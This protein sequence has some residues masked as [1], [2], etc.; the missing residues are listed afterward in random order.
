MEHGDLHCTDLCNEDNMAAFIVRSR[1]LIRNVLKV[2][3]ISVL[4]SLDPLK[5]TGGGSR[6]HRTCVGSA[7]DQSEMI[8]SIYI[9]YV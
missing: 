8:F 2:Y 3:V 6:D 4:G 9:K 1:S 5:M 7:K